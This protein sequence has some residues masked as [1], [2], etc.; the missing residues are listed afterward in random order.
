VKKNIVELVCPKCRY[1]EIIDINKEDIKKCPKCGTGML[2]NE[3]L[4]EG[5]SY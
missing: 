3:I 2:I 5:K 1:V 4:K